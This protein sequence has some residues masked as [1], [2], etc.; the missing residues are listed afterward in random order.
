MKTLT[1]NDRCLQLIEAACVNTLHFSDEQVRKYTSEPGAATSYAATR[2][3]SQCRCVTVGTHDFGQWQEERIV[4]RAYTIPE[5]LTEPIALTP[6]SEAYL[7]HGKK[8][9]VDFEKDS[10]LV[11]RL[12]ACEKPTYSARLPPVVA[13]TY[14]S[15]LAISPQALVR[16]AHAGIWPE[17]VARHLT[18]LTN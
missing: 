1:E 6:G 3:M 9:I 17:T 12:E 13:R 7:Y 2:I 18:T 16:L 5:K 8:L 4:V 10:V 11:V 14:Y 15:L